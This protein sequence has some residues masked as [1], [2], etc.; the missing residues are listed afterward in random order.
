MQQKPRKAEQTG[1]YVVYMWAG[2]CCRP[3]VLWI[4]H[5][6]CNC[7]HSLQVETDKRIPELWNQ[8]MINK[9]NAVLPICSLVLIDYHDSSHKQNTNA[10]P[11]MTTCVI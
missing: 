2:D 3:G 9:C 8:S 5:R 7:I 6:C 11:K 10:K 1:C 4:F